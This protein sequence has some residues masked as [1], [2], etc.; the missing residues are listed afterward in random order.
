MSNDWS[1]K[2]DQVSLRDIYPCADEIEGYGFDLL[3]FLRKK[4]LKELKFY[5]NT[6]SSSGVVTKVV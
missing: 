3:I 5:A 6:L 1:L 4:M 2:S